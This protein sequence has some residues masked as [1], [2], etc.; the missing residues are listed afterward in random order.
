MP[1]GITRT[2]QLVQ[3]LKIEIMA[4]KPGFPRHDLNLPATMLVFDEDKTM[5]KCGDLSR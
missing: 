4:H 1:R 2:E 5:L 3:R